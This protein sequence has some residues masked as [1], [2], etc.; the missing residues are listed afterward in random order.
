MAEFNIEDYRILD[1]PGMLPP[2]VRAYRIRKGDV[3]FLNDIAMKEL[4]PE[5]IHMLKKF[6]L[7]RDG[8]VYGMVTKCVWSKKKWWQ[9]WKKKKWLGCEVEIL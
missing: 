6:P 2:Y 9:F 8:Y 4:C 5:P 3:L 7:D 1:N